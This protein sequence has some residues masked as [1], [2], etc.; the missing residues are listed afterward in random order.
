MPKLR[1]NSLHFGGRRKP[2]L[3]PSLFLLFVSVLLGRIV[4]LSLYAG[5]LPFWDQWDAEAD[6]LLR[7]WVEGQLHFSALFAPHN[8]HRIFFSRVLSLALFVLN[9]GQWDNLVEVYANAILYAAMLSMLCARLCDISQ[10]AWQR[11]GFLIIVLVTS[12]QPFAWEN[13]LV[14]FQSQFYFMAAMAISMI[15]VAACRPISRSAIWILLLL[16]AASLVTMASG[17]LACVPVIAVVFMRSWRDR[18]G[19]KHVFTT[20]TI[21]VFLTVIGLALVPNISGH[22]AM[23]AIG[24]KEHLS[25]TLT[26]LMWPFQSFGEHNWP[27]KNCLAIALIMWMPSLV[28]LNQFVRLRKASNAEL[29]AAGIAFWVILQALAIAHSRGHGMNALASRYMDISAIGLLVNTWFALRMLPLPP[30][31]SFA[32]VRFY[33]A[34]FVFFLMAS[35][36]LAIRFRVDW[37]GMVN[38]HQLVVIQ[39]TNVREYVRTQDSESLDQPLLHIPYPN[40]AQLR[41]FL[42]NPTIHSMLP[43]SIRSPLALNFD[44]RQGGFHTGGTPD[45]LSDPEGLI[46]YGSYQED[47]HTAAIS[48]LDSLIFHTTFPYIRMS[49]TTGSSDVHDLRLQLTEGKSSID[50]DQQVSL[51]GS[52]YP[53][54]SDRY[55][56]LSAT[57]IQ[58]K[59]FAT[60]NANWLAFSAPVE[61]GHLSMYA[62][63]IQNAVRNLLGFT[64]PSTPPSFRRLVA[65]HAETLP[66]TDAATYAS[67]AS[68]PVSRANCAIDN[69]N[70]KFV[71]NAASV[72][73][74]DSLSIQGWVVNSSDEAPSYFDLLLANG[75]GSYGLKAYTGISRPDVAKVLHSDTARSAGF[76]IIAQSN[77]VPDGTYRVVINLVNND[78]IETCDTLKSIII[79]S[80]TGP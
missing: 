9:S 52:V 21:M 67:I 25:A 37:S 43:I 70:D 77:N 49:V 68:K 58:L 15:G 41:V 45:Q 74:H 39:T 55:I 16:G 46:T 34:A 56:P 42:D 6:S 40:P 23:K 26:A 33:T 4:Y 75:A 79:G 32:S 30:V 76:N 22:A 72:K 47:P 27:I 66:N 38:R 36:G 50:L 48:Q 29:F 69:V 31:A 18:S 80:D 78:K 24:V 51:D 14:G 64:E 2:S 35:Y 54:W 28:W 5:D 1:V 57:D 19:L 62:H 63:R 13:T 7:P 65:T 11:A 71:N 53:D 3:R 61:L 8:E 10:N 59:A 17:V 44:M 12:L 60:S 20:F 73:L